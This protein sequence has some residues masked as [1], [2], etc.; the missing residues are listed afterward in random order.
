L[1]SRVTT[2]HKNLSA[3]SLAGATPPKHLDGSVPGDYG[4]DPLRLGSKPELLKYFSIGEVIN[5]RWAMLAVVGILAQEALG[6]GDWWTAGAQEY[7]VDLQTQ[8]IVG[9]PTFAI[10]E[11]LRASSNDIKFQDPMGMDSAETRLKEIKNGRLAMVAFIGFSSQAAVQG[12]GPIA[13]LQKHLE[14]PAHNNIFTSSVGNEAVVAVMAL[15]VAPI[16]IEAKN[17]LSGSNEDEFRPIP[18]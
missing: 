13:C 18:W 3:N 6:R 15:S 10:L 12:L 1:R 4:F 9:I 14:D 2:Q 11:A 17:K 8:L 5:G 7:P 16:I